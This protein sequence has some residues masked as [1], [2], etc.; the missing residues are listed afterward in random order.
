MARDPAT[1][2]DAPPGGRYVQVTHAPRSHTR[3][4][5]HVADQGNN[6]SVLLCLANWA[7]RHDDYKWTGCLDPW[8]EMQVSGQL[9]APA[10]A[11]P[12]STICRRARVDCSD[13]RNIT[14][15]TV[16]GLDPRSASRYA[17]DFVCTLHTQGQC[18]RAHL[19]RHTQVRSGGLCRCFLDNVSLACGI[20]WILFE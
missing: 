8:H 17:D 20:T 6:S 19:S 3:T 11:P 7:S 2:E 5:Q 14:D 1:R 4:D 9:H 13:N 12:P 18:W 16:P 10:T 15:C